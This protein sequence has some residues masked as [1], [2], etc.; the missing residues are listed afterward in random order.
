MELDGRKNKPRTT[1]NDED[2]RWNECGEEKLGEK[3]GRK[4]Q[5]I[6]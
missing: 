2:T 4:A 6:G 5:Q 3:G 1:E